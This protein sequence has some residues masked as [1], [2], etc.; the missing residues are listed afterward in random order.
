MKTLE[1]KLKLFLAE[2]GLNEEMYDVLINYA[3]IDEN[4]VLVIDYERLMENVKE[5]LELGIKAMNEAFAY[6]VFTAKQ[7]ANLI[8]ENADG[9]EKLLF[10]DQEVII[11]ETPPKVRYPGFIENIELDLEEL[12]KYRDGEFDLNIKIKS[13][14]NQ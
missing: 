1:I 9:T 10:R 7:N 4:D 6:L 11:K 8:F 5:G 13:G 2:N 3:S 12:G 14:N